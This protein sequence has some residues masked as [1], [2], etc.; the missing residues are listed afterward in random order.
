MPPTLKVPPTPAESVKPMET[1]ALKLPVNPSVR[2]PEWK[3][4]VVR[5]RMPVTLAPTWASMPSVTGT[6]PTMIGSPFGATFYSISG[7][8]AIHVLIGLSILAASF[9]G[10]RRAKL[11]LASLFIHFLNL[12]WLLLWPT[13]YWLSTDLKEL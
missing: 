13:L 3:P 12:I 6:G 11:G 10:S 1:V 5:D 4:A 8:Y 7:F 9:T 2:L